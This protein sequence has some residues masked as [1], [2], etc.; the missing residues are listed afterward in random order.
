MNNKLFGFF[1]A[2]ACIISTNAF[3][4]TTLH[5][6]VSAY[7]REEV[8]KLL[9][10]KTDINAKDLSSM[11]PLHY[12]TMLSN[13]QD[14]NAYFVETLLAAGAHCNVMDNDG[15]TPLHWACLKGNLN[16]TKKLV[17]HYR[18]HNQL[19]GIN[20]QSISYK[21]TPLHVAIRE[22]NSACA[23]ELI[24]NGEADI[25]IVSERGTHAN[26]TMTELAKECCPELVPLLEEIEQ[27]DLE[28]DAATQPAQWYDSLLPLNFFKLI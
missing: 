8:G 17:A 2:A 16:A 1:L 20:A 21:L 18:D 12:A 4:M 25:T 27:N 10:E 24:L 11:T 13:E 28:N 23:R 3:S 7:N 15:W 5:Q 26:K 9:G 22:G 14:P 6:A 19:D